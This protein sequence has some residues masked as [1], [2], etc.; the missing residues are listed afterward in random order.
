MPG[1]RR[2]WGIT[3]SE[4]LGPRS[5]WYTPEQGIYHQSKPD[6]AALRIPRPPQPHLGELS[7]V[8]RRDRNLNPDNLLIGTS[9]PTL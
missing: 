3:V 2:I 6:H 5:W 9:R 7:A 1:N 8:D 4:G